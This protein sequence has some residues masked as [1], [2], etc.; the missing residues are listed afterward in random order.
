MSTIARIFLMTVFGLSIGLSVNAQTSTKIKMDELPVAAHDLIHGKYAKYRV[1]SMVKK[2]DKNE[3]LTYEVELQRK[4]K[5]INLTYNAQ[6]DLLDTQKSKVFS[7]DGSERPSRPS[8]GGGDG[9]SGHS[10]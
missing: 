4:S 3:V 5:V 8:G 1:N 7:F 6:G 9:H 2:L 10:H